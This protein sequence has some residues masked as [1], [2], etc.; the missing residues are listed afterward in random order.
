MKHPKTLAERRY[1]DIVFRQSRREL[2]KTWSSS[3]SRRGDFEDN[4][5]WFAVKRSNIHGNRCMCHY[6]KNDKGCKRKTRLGLDVKS[7]RRSM[8]LH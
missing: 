2:L 1:N 4:K 8:Q 5:W 3:S 6:E 7:R